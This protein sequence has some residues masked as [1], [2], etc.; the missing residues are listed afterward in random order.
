MSRRP[1]AP[2]RAR[3]GSGTPDPGRGPA[4]GRGATA[5]E[6]QAR[7]D[8][9]PAQARRPAPHAAEP[10]GD[11][12]RPARLA[13]LLSIRA[14]VLAVVLL[15]GFT[16]LFPTVRAYLGQRAELAA[17]E[18]SVLDAEQ[19]EKDLEAELARWDDP[20]YVQAQARARLS[21][22]FPGETA[23]RVI[24][25]EVV[26]E[27]VLAEGAPTGDDTGPTLPIDGSGTPWY[28]TIWSSVQIA[29][30]LDVVDPDAPAEEPADDDTD[31]AP[32]DQPAGDT[33]PADPSGTT[34]TEETE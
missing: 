27:E 20:A 34:D 16:L 21:F 2:Q 33:D 7:R 12:P 3:S 22:V 32:Q 17:L 25:P 4:R 9:R 23:Y 11:E 24:D 19:H 6:D 13:R 15:V 29:G 5:G 28:T 1:V 14:L 10:E 18:Q 30:E 31:P 26:E 8:T